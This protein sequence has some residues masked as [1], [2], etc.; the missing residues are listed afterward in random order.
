MARDALAALIL[1]A[2]LA[3]PAGGALAGDALAAVPVCSADGRR[4]PAPDRPD[5]HAP[6]LCAHAL[7]E[8][9]G[10]RGGARS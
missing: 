10:R 6:M 2:L 4:P 5:D 1:L 8:R 3:G 9:H 7:S